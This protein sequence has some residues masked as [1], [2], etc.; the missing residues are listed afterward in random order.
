MENKDRHLFTMGQYPFEN[1]F[2]HDLIPGAGNKIFYCG[3]P[4]SEL[5]MI[6]GGFTY[7]KHY[8]TGAGWFSF[9]FI[10]G[11]AIEVNVYIDSETSQARVGRVKFYSTGTGKKR[12]PRH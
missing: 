1:L 12:I 11:D 4:L 9:S 7:N 10:F 5:R 3:M 8:V 6:A 2:R